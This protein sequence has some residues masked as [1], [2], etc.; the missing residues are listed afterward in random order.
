M[1]NISSRLLHQ[2]KVLATYH[3]LLDVIK[4]L[5]GDE[6]LPTAAALRT[7]LGVS[8]ETLNLALREL[9]HHHLIYSVRGVGIYVTPRRRTCLL[10][11]PLLFHAED[12]S[13]FW[14]VLVDL[15]REHA[16]ARNEEFMFRFAHPTGFKGELLPHDVQQEIE[17]GS[18]TG[19]LGVGISQ[20]ISNWLEER[21]SLVTFASHS[22]Y[23]VGLNAKSIILQ[24]I[25]ELAGLGCCDIAFWRP[26]S[27][28]RHASIHSVGDRDLDIFT[29]ALQIHKL[30][31][32]PSLT[33]SQTSLL[34]YKGSLAKSEQG[35]NIAYEV[36]G[37]EGH[38]LPDGIF[39]GD[40][41]MTV[42]VLKAFKEMDVKVGK[43][44]RV[45]SHGNKGTNILP[46]DEELT[47]FEFDPWEIAYAMFSMLN[48]LFQGHIPV[49]RNLE[50]MAKMRIL[51]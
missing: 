4:E 22:K 42:G 47:V 48:E 49:S 51:A 27:S 45:V 15:I 14:Q 24:A 43:D 19:V 38:K 46:L 29:D 36:F 20:E 12:M 21:I 16:A 10:V 7:Q 30:E 32:M 33:N 25:D 44:V 13:P 17:G 8:L 23:N 50:I 41:M 1:T 40:D 35:Y 34:F 6:K 3:K 37:K 9:E 11:D 31:F 18:V 2:P 26:Y 28:Y 5:R 39:I